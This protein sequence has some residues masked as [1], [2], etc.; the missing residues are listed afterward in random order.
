MRIDSDVN[1]PVWEPIRVQS[2]LFDAWA[3]TSGV[4]YAIITTQTTTVRH[5]HTL[6]P[7]LLCARSTKV[8]TKDGTTCFSR[9]TVIDVVAL[10][11]WSLRSRVEVATNDRQEFGRVKRGCMRKEKKDT[12]KRGIDEKASSDYIRSGVR[13]REEYV[14]KWWRPGI[15]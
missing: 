4:V 14:K 7:F 10:T 8:L 3:E 1:F 12:A 13:E 15:A 9:W 5:Y 6:S 2:L 11:W